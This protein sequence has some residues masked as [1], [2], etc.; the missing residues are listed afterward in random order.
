ME[1]S[2]IKDGWL[3]TAV[4]NLVSRDGTKGIEL[5]GHVHVACARYHE[6]V[7]K[8][9]KSRLALRCPIMLDWV[10]VPDAD[11]SEE[12]SALLAFFK[13][14]LRYVQESMQSSS[15]GV[16]HS[17]SL[18]AE[19]LLGHPGV[20]TPGEWGDILGLLRTNKGLLEGL[21]RCIEEISQ[22]EHE[23]VNFGSNEITQRIASADFVGPAFPS[24][25]RTI[26]L[27]FR[28]AKA[29]ESML[30]TPEEFATGVW[31]VG[32]LPGMLEILQGSGMVIDQIEWLRARQL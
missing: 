1:I 24:V 8:R 6:A 28:N 12:G 30:V 31:G 3:E 13:L 27:D 4:I 5:I 15:N 20:F 21:Y 23:P 32:H 11:S 2:R 25:L 26:L 29:C 19:H 22:H 17:G 14:L 7:I 16:T 9:C 10:K 18:F